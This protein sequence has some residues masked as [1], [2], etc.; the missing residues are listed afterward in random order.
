MPFQGEGFEQSYNAQAGVDTESMLVV[1]I[2]V[3]QAAN[4]KQQ[5]EPMLKELKPACPRSIGKPVKHVRRQWLLQLGQRRGLRKPVRSPNRC[6]L[7]GAIN[8]TQHW[9]RTIR[10]RPS[11]TGKMSC[12]LRPWRIKTSDKVM[13]LYALRKQMVEPVFGII[14]SVL[15]FRQFLLRGLDSSSR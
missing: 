12:R 1:A 14:K 3:V 9:R 7:R 5:I 2:D 4:D 13:Q 11:R 10:R 15:G 6:L 8:I